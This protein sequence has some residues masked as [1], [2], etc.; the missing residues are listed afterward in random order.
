MAS[1]DRELRHAQQLEG[2][3]LEVT[4]GARC[5]RDS[6]PNGERSRTVHSIGGA[7]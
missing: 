5:S 3:M 6:D 7:R 4:A 2:E 1:E